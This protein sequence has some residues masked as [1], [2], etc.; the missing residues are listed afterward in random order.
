MV[1]DFNSSPEYNMPVLGVPRV[2]IITYWGKCLAR[3]PLLGNSRIGLNNLHMPTHHF[4]VC[5][6]DM[7]QDYYGP[8]SVHY[9]DEAHRTL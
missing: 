3:P 7:I 8:L 6:R 1:T 4:E 5:V 2:R 9:L